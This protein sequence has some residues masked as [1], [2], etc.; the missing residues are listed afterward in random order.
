[1]DSCLLKQKNSESTMV[2]TFYQ[3]N[4]REETVKPEKKIRVKLICI[5]PQRFYLVAKST[6]G[7]FHSLFGG[8]IERIN[9][10][11]Y[12]LSVLETL[13]K[14]FWEETSHT[15]SIKFEERKIIYQKPKNLYDPEGPS[16]HE[17]RSQ[18]SSTECS[19]PF[20]Y[21][22]SFHEHDTIFNVI[23]I[24]KINDNLLD[25]W[26]RDI[27]VSQET[28]MKNLFAGWNIDIEKLFEVNRVYHQKLMKMKTQY[29][30]MPKP[31]FNF[32]CAKLS[33]YYNFF[34]KKGIEILEEEEFFN[35][36]NI[37]EWNTMNFETVR[38][39][40]EELCQKTGVQLG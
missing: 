35:S 23:H 20:V 21:I 19:L 34:E 40:L 1:M 17:S 6:V 12:F 24:P 25:M 14:E 36:K 16:D 31:I 11:N 22:G 28:L 8:V 33:N 32:I 30:Y 38:K 39:K 13:E 4:K 37:W 27:K 2:P 18:D 15:L 5:L 3:S 9:P 26:N 7:D 10:K 29:S